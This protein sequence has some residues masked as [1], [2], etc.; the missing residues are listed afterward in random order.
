MT[1]L[2]ARIVAALDQPSQLWEQVY[3]SLTPEAQILFLTLAS[4]GDAM[5]ISDLEEAV[6]Q[7]YPQSV[8]RFLSSLREL[9]D[10]FV[11]TSQTGSAEIVNFI[12]P[13]MLDYAHRRFDNSP[14]A[15]RQFLATATFMDQPVH[16]AQ[17]AAVRNETGAVQYPRLGRWVQQ[18]SDTV[19]Q[20][21]LSAI[22][23]N[24][25]VG[26][27]IYRSGS[28][29]IWRFDSFINFF[30]RYGI[31]DVDGA[32]ARLVCEYFDSLDERSSVRS[33][34]A[35]LSNSERRDWIRRHSEGDRLSQAI[36]WAVQKARDESDY[37][38]VA[39]LIEL[40]EAEREDVTAAR[41]AF[42]TYLNDRVSAVE[43][44]DDVDDADTL[45]QEM[46]ELETLA[47]RFGI[48]FDEAQA[49]FEDALSHMPPD[50]EDDYRESA[51]D[52]GSGGSGA[53]EG[54]GAELSEIDDM[55]S[56]LLERES[57][58]DD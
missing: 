8:G 57:E 14:E 53:D 24:A 51:T 1:T 47:G 16:V 58:A 7:V 43:N 46:E 25:R 28:L 13:S 39:D 40:D 37:D 52:R 6:A 50:K 21:M 10:T 27:G 41:A 32:A 5:V 2:T 44:G 26:S 4:V 3:D 11:T 23:R 22:G 9:D 17:L 45:V 29:R 38:D 33:V 18:N 36:T 54:T 12:N 48:D 19:G 49:V 35:L 15:V 55:F 20:A 56:H 31:E 34:T 42:T 30:I